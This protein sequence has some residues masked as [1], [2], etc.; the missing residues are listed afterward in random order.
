MESYIIKNQYGEYWAGSLNYR[1][2][3]VECV[4]GARRIPSLECAMEFAVFLE[5]MSEM[6]LTVEPK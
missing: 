5:H 1:D 2:C 4:E 6:K 3:W